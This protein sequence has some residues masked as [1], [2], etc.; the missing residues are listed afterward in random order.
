MMPVKV[1]SL[2]ASRAFLPPWACR[3]FSINVS[4]FTLLSLAIT[5]AAKATPVKMAVVN[6][7]LWDN[8]MQMSSRLG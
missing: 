7:I 2:T 5:G 1:M 4:T 6:T 3:F 8:F